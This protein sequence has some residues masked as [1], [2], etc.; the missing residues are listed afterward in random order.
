MAYCRDEEMVR[1]Y[2]KVIA[3]R[4]TITREIARLRAEARQLKAESKAREATLPHI[5]RP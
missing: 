5:R 4:Q 3:R 2:E 1:D